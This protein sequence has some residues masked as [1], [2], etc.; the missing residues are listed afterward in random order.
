MAISGYQLTLEILVPNGYT[1]KLLLLPPMRDIRAESK[2]LEP[3][4]HNERPHNPHRTHDTHTT[5]NMLTSA[6]SPRK[7][8]FVSTSMRL[9]SSIS[10]ADDA[11]C[12]FA[13][14]AK[15]WVSAAKMLN[16]QY[17]MGW[18]SICSGTVGVVALS[19]MYC[20][21]RCQNSL[22]KMIGQ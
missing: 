11:P 9:T 12:C 1:N 3:I 18:N 20:E 8:G 2:E 4:T 17:D 14:S 13:A 16:F 22:G 15:L 6:V 7:Y 19:S 21:R 10:E 5:C